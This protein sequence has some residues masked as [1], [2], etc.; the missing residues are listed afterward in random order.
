M[1]IALRADFRDVWFRRKKADRI[2]TFSS[3]KSFCMAAGCLKV[4]YLTSIMIGDGCI[5]INKYDQLY[6]NA[7]FICFKNQDTALC[8]PAASG[9]YI[10]SEDVAA[11]HLLSV[12]FIEVELT[13][14]KSVYVAFEE[15]GSVI[16]VVKK[17]SEK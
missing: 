10:I 9:F 8:D 1:S 2:K 15:E 17:F 3:V 5:V 13:N 12:G 6:E 7:D 4:K 16:D 14:N 11:I